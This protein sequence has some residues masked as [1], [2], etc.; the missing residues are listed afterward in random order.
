[1]K[2]NRIPILLM[3]KSNSISVSPYG[4]NMSIT[5]NSSSKKNKNKN[6]NSKITNSLNTDEDNDNN[7]KFNILIK[8]KNTI[9]QKLQNQIKTLL[10]NGDEKDRKIKMQKN[11]IESLKETNKNLQEEINNK[12]VIIQQNKNIE[13]KIFHMQKEYLE[14]SNNSTGNNFL[15]IQSIKEYMNKL[16]EKEEEIIKYKKSINILKLNIKQKENEITKKNNL[17]KKYID[18]NRSRS[19]SEIKHQ[20]LNNEKISI[21][22]GKKAKSM[23]NYSSEISA[24][25]FKLKNELKQNNIRTNKPN[26][27]LNENIIYNKYNSANIN[28]NNKNNYTK[29][30]ENYNDIKTKCKYYYNFAHHLKSKNNLLIQEIQKLKT[31]INIL[32]NANNN[33][34]KLL[35]KYQNQTSKDKNNNNNKSKR[36]NSKI[37]KK[38]NNNIQLLLNTNNN[39]E[40]YFNEY[41]K[42]LNNE[43]NNN[44]CIQLDNNIKNWKQNINNIKIKNSIELISDDE[45]DKNDNEEN[46]NLNNN[47]NIS[48]YNKGTK[49]LYETLEQY[50]ELCTKKEKE[51][52]LLKIKLEEKENIIQSQNSLHDKI[53][54]YLTII[55]ELETTNNKNNEIIENKNKEIKKLNN[56]KKKNEEKIKSLDKKISEG[57]KI[58]DQ[59]N[60]KIEILNNNIKEKEIEINKLNSELK[61]KEI[62]IKEEQINSLI[63][64]NSSELSKEDFTKKI[65]ELQS[66]ISQIKK[67]LSENKIELN[68]LI[69]ENNFL[70][71]KNVELEGMLTKIESEKN[72]EIKNLIEEK[73]EKNNQLEDLVKKLNDQEID[74]KGVKYDNQELIQGVKQCMNNMRQNEIKINKL[75]I[76]NENLIKTNQLLIEEKNR[77]INS[78]N[79]L[80]IE[81]KEKKENI[82]YLQTILIQKTEL[83]EQLQKSNDEL[84]IQVNNIKNE[85]KQKHIELNQYEIQYNKLKHDENFSNE[86]VNL[87]EENNKIIIENK[88]LQNKINKLTNENN[89]YNLKLNDL[90]TKYQEQKK[91]IQEKEKELNYMKEA[92]K[93]ILEKH[94]KLAEE[95]NQQINPNSWILITSKKYNKLTWYLLQKKSDS[96]NSF[97]NN[98]YNKFIWVNGNTLT[99]E[100]LKKYNKFEDDEQKIKDL[101]EYNYNLQKKLERKEESINILDYKNKKLMEQ[102]Q[103]KTFANTGN[104]KL[105][106]NLGKN[107]RT[108]SINNNGSMGERGFESETFKNILH[109]LNSSNIRESKLQKEVTQ[110]KEKLKKKEEFEAGFP[111][112]FK[113]I[114]PIGNDSGFLDDDLRD[115]EKKCIIDLVKSNTDERDKLSTK[116]SATNNND[117]IEDNKKLKEENS[118]L[119]NKLKELEIKNKNL[120]KM[121]KDSQ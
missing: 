96:K 101:Q 23:K 99:K 56:I 32:N 37:N 111:K 66:F 1:M 44:N 65:N 114:E 87:I 108:N 39:N 91:L 82:N 98:I 51:I 63:K 25:N 107:D 59:L 76:Q 7:Y 6:S 73:E 95:C 68:N 12:N 11:I 81:I 85:L 35:A 75:I 2:Y 83:I 72:I 34:K 109:Q 10:Y 93:A 43:S 13:K 52:N 17:L 47:N 110:L 103:N 28:Y 116:Y 100:E 53:T 30:L 36:K 71:N 49:K 119:K 55:S 40:L 15:Y 92:S 120:E 62:L 33:L 20:K 41:D 67:E 50:R 78:I 105:K 84:I 46:N 70:K 77:L 21:S 106:F 9:I 86:M 45:K 79:S 27:L 121:L 74:F 58:K 54:E 104:N 24:N 69:E 61:D 19:G 90:N 48:N 89:T 60:E 31:N 16:N 88:T 102:I 5:Y 42:Q 8:E 64:I 94:K 113:D 112:H 80:M 3:S 14:E 118:A 26:L 117:N 57:K 4:K 38:Q 22:T 29:L 97:N 18:Y 115:Q